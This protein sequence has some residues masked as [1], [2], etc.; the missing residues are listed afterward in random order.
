MLAFLPL[1]WLTSARDDPGM[2]I[3]ILIF[4]GM[5]DLDAFGPFE[6]LTG[7]RIDTTFVTVEPADYVTSS[8]G[9]RIVPHGVVGDPDLVLVPG[10]GWNDKGG[11]YQQAKLGTIPAFMKARHEAGRR[12]GS[13]CTG[14]MLLAEAG[15][16]SGRRACTHHTS[17]EELRSHGVEVLE[18]RF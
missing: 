10:G 2:K 6:V 7:A 4:D 18:E 5:D 12:V 11:A 14:A 9:A 3:E 15:I 16:L 13:V 8:G 17:H 1:A